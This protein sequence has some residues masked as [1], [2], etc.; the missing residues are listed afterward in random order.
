M[1]T[2]S[3]ALKNDFQKISTAFS[4]SEQEVLKKKSQ[5]HE[6]ETLVLK[7]KE[8]VEKTLHALKSD[9][10]QRLMRMFRNAADEDGNI[11]QSFFKDLNYLLLNDLL[12]APEQQQQFVK[13][14]NGTDESFKKVV[15]DIQKNSILKMRTYNSQLMWLKDAIPVLEYVLDGISLVSM[16][17]SDSVG[18]FQLLEYD[19]VTL[20]SE[21]KTQFD[22]VLKRITEQ[23]GVDVTGTVY[24]PFKQRVVGIYSKLLALRS[25]CNE[26]FEMFGHMRDTVF[27]WMFYEDPSLC[28]ATDIGECVETQVLEQADDD[29]EDM[30]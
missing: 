21:I 25:I 22:F 10:L 23:E 18:F 28:I 1:V 3:R 11:L 26:S 29:G 9:T 4:Q 20:K 19:L 24:D 12:V 7:R 15:A 8:E 5:L 30:E 13:E 16:G 2:K 27:T 6:N 14:E 17:V